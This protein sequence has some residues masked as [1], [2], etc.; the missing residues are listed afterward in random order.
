[1]SHLYMKVLF[2]RYSFCLFSVPVV[3]FFVD[4]PGGGLVVEVEDCGVEYRGEIFKEVDARWSCGHV[5]GGTGINW[6]ALKVVGGHWRYVAYICPGIK[7]NGQA[8]G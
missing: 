2:G 6:S 5:H 3:A 8:N 1:M 4:A 7:S